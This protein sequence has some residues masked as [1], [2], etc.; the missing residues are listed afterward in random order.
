MLT[1]SFSTWLLGKA[2]P[3][4]AAFLGG[5]TLFMFWTPER[6]LNKGKTAAAFIAGA[7]A[8]VVG[9][10]FTGLFLMTLGI[11]QN[12]LDAVI[13]AAWVLGFFSVAVLNWIANWI[14]K[15]SEKDILEVAKEIKDF[16]G[17]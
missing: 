2:A 4:I 3:T 14:D 7:I 5:L 6:L 13:G 9:F 10:A 12:H 16:K 15:R 11:D 17:G 8:A 1:E